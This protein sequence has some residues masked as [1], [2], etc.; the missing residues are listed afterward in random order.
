M[1]SR[2][3]RLAA[4]FLLLRAL[5]RWGCIL[6]A[7]RLCVPL[8]TTSAAPVDLWSTA[9][10]KYQLVVFVWT[11]QAFKFAAGDFEGLDA[12]EIPVS[13]SSAYGRDIV[14][15]NQFLFLDAVPLD[16][17]AG[18]RRR[19]T[20]SQDR[21]HRCRW[22]LRQICNQR[23]EAVDFAEIPRQDTS[24]DESCSPP[25]PLARIPNT[26]TPLHDHLG[27]AA[28][29]SGTC[30]PQPSPGEDTTLESYS[31]TY[32]ERPFLLSPVDSR[33]KWLL[34]GVSHTVC[35]SCQ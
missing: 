4:S 19:G 24:L 28:L 33:R 7:M 6:S 34:G 17:V 13:L 31:A 16:G 5:G 27:N 2:R 8:W 15:E 29:A 10:A 14:S 35:H 20:R 26:Y 23:V 3:S 11:P 32:L 1:S 12:D 21:N 18:I 22:D 30:Q 9:Q 25:W